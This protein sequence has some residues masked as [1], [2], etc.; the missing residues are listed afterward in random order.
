M[1]KFIVGIDIGGT[2]TDL[3]WMNKFTGEVASVKVPSTPPRYIDGIIKAL[4]AAEINTKD[5]D[6][7]KHG[8][9]LVYNTVLQRK[10]SKTALIT[11]SGFR[12]IL[13]VARGERPDHF[14]FLWDAGPPLVARRNR[15]VV[16][17]RIDYQGEIIVDLNLEDVFKVIEAIKKRDI[18]SV[19]ICFINSYINPLHEKTIKKI[20]KQE[21]PEVYVT[22]SYEIS[23][24]IKEFERV[25][26][27]VVNAY[28]GPIFER[29]SAELR[30]RLA[31]E[32]YKNSVLFAHSS[33]GVMAYDRA[34]KV[35]AKTFLS[36]P[37]SGVIGG[38]YVGEKLTECSKFITLDM[39][40][41]SSDIGLVCDGEPLIKNLTNIE[42]NVPVLFPCIDIASIGVGGN[43]I[44]WLDTIGALKCGP[45]ST[46]ICPGPACYGLGGVEPTLTDAHLVLGW[47]PPEG[48]LEGNLKLKPD[49]ARRVI[50]KKIA[51]PL[52]IDLERAAEGIIELANYNIVNAIK[53]VCSEKGYDPKEFVLIAHGGIGPLHAVGI[54]SKLNISK[55]I[56]PAL[57]GVMSAFGLIIA[58]KKYDGNRS[59][60]KK[61]EEVNVL[62]LQAICQE[63]KEEAI[64]T[65]ISE[66]VPEEKI[67]LKYFIE[68]KYHSASQ[69][70]TLPLKLDLLKTEETIYV[71]EDHHKQHKLQFGYTLPQQF[72]SVEIIC[73]RVVGY[74]NTSL[75]T[76]LIIVDKSGQQEDSRT[77]YFGETGGYKI[78][79]VLERKNLKQGSKLKGPIIIEDKNTTILVPGDA[80]VEIDA[81]FNIF[82]EFS[83]R[84]MATKVAKL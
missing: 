6:L 67:E 33:G 71:I 52:K 50:Q 24:E 37:A 81:N 25:S 2:F 1:S 63:L 57:S 69:S 84:E 5:I 12:D 32:G 29:Y 11:T 83:A 66:G 59:V 43:S 82:I 39:G 14:N 20:I 72:V 16:S 21:L 55:I 47:L 10:G 73:I 30:S 3:L 68:T 9:N 74:D 60:M 46:E 79:T 15:F 54:A 51:N 45:Q 41:N 75:Q 49:L 34:S 26:S 77:A 78:T 7:I 70:V 35:P 38:K 62:K 22:A 58:R 44:A 53:A 76:P 18:Q 65:L 64:T 36:G 23:P 61:I 4:N 19:A 17:E 40:G 80:Q 42:F 48:L 13:E 8:S 31:E 28:L 56:I 27:T